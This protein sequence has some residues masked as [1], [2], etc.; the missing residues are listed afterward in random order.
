MSEAP[1][2]I[3]VPYH[4]DQTMV[5][6]C[7]A[8]TTHDISNHAL[9]PADRHHL[10]DYPTVYIIRS[11]SHDVEDYIVY[12]GETNSIV[13]RTGEHYGDESVYH[14]SEGKQ[15]WHEINSG[16][17]AFMYVVAHSHFNKSLT[18]DLENTFMSYVLASGNKNVRLV[19]SRGNP[20][21]D[22]YTHNELPRLV[23]QAWRKLSRHEPEVFPAESAI[24]DSAIF[25]ASPF[26]RL[27]DE[28][29]VAEEAIIAKIHVALD[30][31]EGTR[32]LILVEGAAGTGKTVLISHLFYQIANEFG[33]SDGA[34]DQCHEANLIINHDE[35]ATVYDA[36]MMR[37]G[38]QK[39]PGVIVKKPT[40]FINQH[41]E[42]GHGSGLDHQDFPANPIDVALIDEAHLLLN[43]GNQGY[44][45]SRNM[46]VDVL[47]RARVVVAVYDPNQVLRSSQEADP[48]VL[49]ELFPE[50][51]LSNGQT[52][53]TSRD[54]KLGGEPCAVTNIHLTHQFRIDA[55]DA[56]VEWI[57][58]FASGKCI[59]PIPK[60]EKSD[61]HIPYEIRVFDSPFDLKMAIEERAI[62]FDKSGH[63]VDDDAHGLSRV[64]ATY[65]WRYSS[66]STPK[67]GDEAWEVKLYK[68]GS[69]W[70]PVPDDDV[71]SARQ[72]LEAKGQFF[73]MPWNYQAEPEDGESLRNRAWAEQSHTLG[74]CGSIYTIQGFDLNVAGVIIGP[75]VKYR[76]GRVVFD[77]DSSC[78]RQA[79]AG[80]DDPQ[81][82]LKHELNVLLKRGVHGLY[83]FA[84]DTQLR[85]HLRQMALA[86]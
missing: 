10:T 48:A 22:Y 6:D 84:V 45:G 38:L 63:M 61:G 25:K 36:I 75:S 26:H 7:I 2:V 11:K 30:V 86:S 17:Q 62:T 29:R 82:N 77:V 60:D 15:L 55:S 70:V 4:D 33:M 56:V 21:N 51:R 53:G 46:L 69:E 3:D 42:G 49:Q 37:L 9:T 59:G 71:F 19:N 34:T 66:K 28:Q 80:S 27:G 43:Q 72:S 16:S 74:E 1:V 32:T 73:H 12:V 40:Q 57:E 47:K 81:E 50:E 68:D 78:N 54:I 41:S 58:E 20:Q 39:K 85:D 13:R 35:Q 83:L 64:L 24:R 76:D 67:N 23:S 44:R 79:V 14:S 5:A 18:L 31:E 52:V 8:S 65:D